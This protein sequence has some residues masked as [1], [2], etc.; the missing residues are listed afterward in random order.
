[1]ANTLFCTSLIAVSLNGLTVN[2]LRVSWFTR[3]FKVVNGTSSIWGADGSFDSSGLS[4]LVTEDRDEDE[5]EEA[6]DPESVSVGVKK[7][8]ESAEVDEDD[9]GDREPEA[10]A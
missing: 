3:P 6:G 1:M 10:E 2:A 9:R 8:E 7:S 5:D 4:F